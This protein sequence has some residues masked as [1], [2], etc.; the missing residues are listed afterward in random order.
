VSVH[1]PRFVLTT[2]AYVRRGDRTLMLERAPRG[3]RDVHTGR[4]NGLGGKFL[5][6]ESPEACLRREVREEAGLE[7]EA[8]TWKG[9]IT[10]PSF[11]HGTDVYT[12][13]YLVTRF[14]GEPLASGPEGRLH[15]V[16]TRRLAELP[17]W[18]GDRVF[19]P[20]LDLP[21]V[22]SAT[23]RYVAGRFDG[24]EVEHYPSVD[25]FS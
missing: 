14:A 6:G 19:L 25:S 3:E 22:F 2:L 9:C 4:W 12:F 7:V 23:F 18:E 24:F 21:G 1:G 20:W 11:D 8:A 17:L 10:F 5:A 16:E 15:W 13:V